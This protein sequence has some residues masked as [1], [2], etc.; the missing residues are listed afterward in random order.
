V[1]RRSYLP[2]G[3]Q[4]AASG[5]LPTD[6]G[7]TGQREADEIGLYYYVA[8]W[9]DVEIGHFAQADTIIP[10]ESSA[11]SWNRYA[12]VDYNP[13][14]YTDPT[15]HCKNGDS[16][17]ECLFDQIQKKIRVPRGS[18]GYCYEGSNY[19][20]C[21]AGDDVLILSEYEEIDEN[22]FTELEYNIFMTVEGL[23]DT[24]F[25]LP[26]GAEDFS[27]FDFAF[28]GDIIAGRHNF[29]SPFYNYDL[30]DSFVVY[31]GVSYKRSDVNYFVQGMYGARFGNTLNEVIDFAKQ[32]KDKRYGEELSDDAIFW[33]IK[34]YYDYFLIQE[35]PEMWIE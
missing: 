20:E 31:Q 32:W 10:D 29:D 19:S 21:Y 25:G 6:F 14:N 7:F 8:R 17:L 12:Y 3:A 13:V 35:D 34:G 28:L 26:R 30:E 2:F 27:I 4:W 11:I 9:Y 1:A 5:S 16:Y 23:S 33:I 24:G 22:Q 18:R 15:G